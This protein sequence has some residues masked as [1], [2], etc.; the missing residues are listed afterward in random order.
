[1][2]AVLFVPTFDTK[3]TEYL[4]SGWVFF[5]QTNFDFLNAIFDRIFLYHSKASVVLSSN[6]KRFFTCGHFL[7]SYGDLKIAILAN[8]GQFTRNI[9]RAI[10]A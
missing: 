8:L 3:V 2:R 10:N 7:L 4:C 6:L 1:M 5:L 9:F